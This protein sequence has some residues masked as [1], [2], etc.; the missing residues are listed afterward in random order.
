VFDNQVT[1]DVRKLSEGVSVIDVTGEV[2][3]SAEGALMA[4]YNEVSEGAA[5]AVLFNF[6]EMTYMNSSG[7]GLLVTIL[8]RAQRKGEKLMAYGLKPHFRKVFE[9]TRLSEAITIYED[10]DAAL[11]ATG[12]I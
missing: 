1:A 9:L 11:A 10:E 4:A 8:I 6:E 2:T 3:A 7:I 12:E 5:K